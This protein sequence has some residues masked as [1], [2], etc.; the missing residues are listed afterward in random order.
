MK[1]SRRL[2]MVVRRQRNGR[3]RDL[4]FACF[5]ALV[6]TM[7]ALTVGAHAFGASAHIAQH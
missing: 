4:F 1:L 6:V 5:V 7:G 3:R 2:T